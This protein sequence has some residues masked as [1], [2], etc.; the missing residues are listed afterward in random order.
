MS[1]DDN[2]I[3]G[4]HYRKQTIQPWTYIIENNIPY[5][6]GNI[7]KYITRW[8]DKGGVNDLL[9][10]KHYL[11]KLIEMEQNAEKR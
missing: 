3:A 8:R 6:E 11:E 9:K 4:D 7:I 2:Q 10:A 5:M 1:A